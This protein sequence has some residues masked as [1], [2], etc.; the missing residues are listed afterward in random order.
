[1]RIR[2]AVLEEFGQPLVVQEV[3]LAEPGPGEVLVRIGPAASATPTPTPPPA[4]TRPATRRAYSDTRAPA[5]S[6]RSAPGSPS[7]AR[8]ITWSPSSHPSAVSAST[9]AAPARTAASPSA[10]SRTRGY[11]PD[12]T[13]RLFRDGEP[14][15]HFMGCSTFAEYTVMPEIALAKVNPEAPLDGLRPVRLRPLHRARRRPLHRPGRAR[16]HLRRIRLRPRRPRRRH[17]RAPGR[18]GADHRP[19][20]LR[21]TAWRRPRHHGATE[22]RVADADTVDWIRAETG[23]YGADYTFEATGLVG[24]MRQAVESAREAWGLATMCGVAGRGRAPGDHPALPHHGSPRHR[25]PPSAG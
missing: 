12:G 17:R 9:A 16:L 7:S 10:T 19:R 3:D 11:L 25:A 15:R 24:V 22:V 18:S 1:M 21:R 13:T 2:A 8:V 20:P 6:R 14:L 4:W 23:G 5:S